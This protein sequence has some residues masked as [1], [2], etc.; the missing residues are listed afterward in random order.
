[1]IQVQP[2][3]D[4]GDDEPHVHEDDDEPRWWEHN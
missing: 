3:D 1:M 2:G 4:Q